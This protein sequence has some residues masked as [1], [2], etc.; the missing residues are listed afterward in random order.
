M[1]KDSR[2]SRILHTLIH[3]KFLARSATSDELGKML[4]TNP[5][6]VRRT[7]ALLKEAG[8]VTSS[9]GH[10]GGWCLAMDLAD[11]TL[12]DIYTIVGE[13]SLFTIGLTDEHHNCPIEMA[14]NSSLNE[15]FNEAETLMLRRFKEIT[16]Q[17][18]A[19]QFDEKMKT[20]HLVHQ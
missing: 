7:M 4:N 20:Q 17:S 10:S 16:I 1:R 8:Y 9:K 2:L 19:A 15:V 11:I 6:V 5:V 18:L 3:L 12:F 13:S 14:V